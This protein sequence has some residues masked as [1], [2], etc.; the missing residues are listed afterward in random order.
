MHRL[1]IVVKAHKAADHAGLGNFAERELEDDQDRENNKDR[2]QQKAGKQPDIGL[3][4]G[5]VQPG[6]HCGT[7]CQKGYVTEENR[8]RLTRSAGPGICKGMKMLK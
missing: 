8:G 4:L 6:V 3:P 5:S 7:S 2:D 1:D